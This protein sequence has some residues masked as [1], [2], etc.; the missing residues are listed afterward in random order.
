MKKLIFLFIVASVAFSSCKKDDNSSSGENGGGSSNSDTNFYIKWTMNGTDYNLT[1]ATDSYV[2][3]YSNQ[4]SIGTSS[5]CY[6]FDGTLYDNNE[7]GLEASIGFKKY[8]FL[9]SEWDTDAFFSIFQVG[10]YTYSDGSTQGCFFSYY[11][12]TNDYFS[13]SI[14]LDQ[15]S[16]TFNI[17]SVTPVDPGNGYPYSIIKGTFSCTL[18]SGEVV[19]NGSFRVACEK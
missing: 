3:V 17:T 15:S 16:S 14:F 13:S 1:D 2:L 6:S 10:D 7:V 12:R 18:A 9:N 11:N 4:S 5:S 8:C 19:T